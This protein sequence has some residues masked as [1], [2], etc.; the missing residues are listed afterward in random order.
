MDLLCDVSLLRRIAP[1]CVG[2]LSSTLSCAVFVSNTR[3]S[4]QPRVA[5]LLPNNPTTDARCKTNLL[6]RCITSKTVTIG[7][8]GGAWRRN[9][10]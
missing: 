8:K 5:I 4:A 7:G 2:V 6:L 10:M 9:Q 1:Q 3:Q